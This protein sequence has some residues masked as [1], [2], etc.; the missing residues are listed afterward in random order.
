M[1]AYHLV[2]IVSAYLI[3]GLLYC[4][5]RHSWIPIHLTYPVTRTVIIR[6]SVS[7]TETTKSDTII[8]SEEK[9]QPRF[10]RYSAESES[11]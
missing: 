4:T 11:N 2:D 7:G 3:A 6:A 8:V 10:R 9:T 5:F 1:L